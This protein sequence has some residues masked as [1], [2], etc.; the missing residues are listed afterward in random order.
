MADPRTTGPVTRGA[1]EDFFGADGLLR[2]P[3]ERLPASLTDPGARAFL[4]GIGLPRT[5]VTPLEPHSRVEHGMIRLAELYL[6]HHRL[7]EMHRGLPAGAGDWLVLGTHG[8]VPFAL[9]GVSGAVHTVAGDPDAA[10]A[11]PAHR[12]LHSLARCLMAYDAEVMRLLLA[13]FLDEEQLAWCAEH[14][15]HW[16]E[17]EDADHE[18]VVARFTARLEAAEPGILT[19]PGWQGAVHTLRHGF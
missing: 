13:D 8:E 16:N 18:E 12:D 2:V 3:A 14:L 10:Y 11:R 4:T 5:P 1:L 19:N 7:S 15:P 6:P 17:V 9:D